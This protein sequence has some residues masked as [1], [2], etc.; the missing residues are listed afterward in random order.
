VVSVDISVN[1]LCIQLRNHAVYSDEND[2]FTL[3]I[4]GKT[5]SVTREELKML[6]IAR[7]ESHSALDIVKD[8]LFDSLSEY[9]GF[10]W[11]FIVASP[12]TNTIGHLTES[13]SEKIMTRSPNYLSAFSESGMFYISVTIFSDIPIRSRI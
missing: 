4:C 12:L 11:S 13:E 2:R 1:P 3:C 8:L 6:S 10:R 9:Q 5:I 7:S